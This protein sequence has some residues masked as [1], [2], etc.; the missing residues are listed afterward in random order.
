[1]H[2][3]YAEEKEGYSAVGALGQGL[4]FCTSKTSKLSTSLAQVRH[5]DE[6]SSE[7]GAV[8]GAGVGEV[9]ELSEITLEDEEGGGR[10]S[11]SQ[12]SSILSPKEVEGAKKQPKKSGG[13]ALRRGGGGGQRGG[14]G[15][16]RGGGGAERGDARMDDCT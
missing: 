6:G 15:G 7:G 1:M 11:R 4:Y 9:S 16:Q 12:S 8:R 2:D 13:G 14:G 10:T 5:A 3:G